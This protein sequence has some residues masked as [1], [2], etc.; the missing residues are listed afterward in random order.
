[1]GRGLRAAVNPRLRGLESEGSGQRPGAARTGWQPAPW[2][3]NGQG[4]N[5]LRTGAGCTQQAR[6]VGVNT[7]IYHH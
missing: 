3:L 1:M 2:V 7:L 4:G 5:G 6:H